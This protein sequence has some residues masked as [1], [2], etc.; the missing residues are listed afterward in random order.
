MT[1]HI[2]PIFSFSRWFS[3]ARNDRC[4]FFGSEVAGNKELL[5]SSKSVKTAKEEAFEDDVATGIDERTGLEEGTKAV[6]VAGVT[7]DMEFNGAKVS[8]FSI[9]VKY[10]RVILR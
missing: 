2:L 3:L 8:P 1:R 5:L 6:A 7:E 4:C 9:A 10:L